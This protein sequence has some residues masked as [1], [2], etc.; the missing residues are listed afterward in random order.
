VQRDQRVCAPAE[1]TQTF[2]GF[3]SLLAET[4]KKITPT[5]REKMTHAGVCV[6]F[7]MVKS[8]RKAP[9]NCAVFGQAGIQ[10]Q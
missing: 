4:L 1:R 5:R 3:G 10:E 7:V 9:R 6:P 2:A 8:D